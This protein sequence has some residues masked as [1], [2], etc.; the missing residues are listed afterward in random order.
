VIARCWFYLRVLAG[1]LSI[2]EADRTGLND[3]GPPERFFSETGVDGRGSLW[4]FTAADESAAHAPIGLVQEGG[5]ESELAALA[6][7]SRW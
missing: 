7:L 6:W 3:E 5:R 4:W 1:A 2:E